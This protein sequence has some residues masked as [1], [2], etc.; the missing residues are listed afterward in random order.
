MPVCSVVSDKDCHLSVHF[1]QKRISQEPIIESITLAHRRSAIVQYNTKNIFSQLALAIKHEKKTHKGDPKRITGMIILIN[2]SFVFL[3]MP[4]VVLHFIYSLN[5]NY[6]MNISW[7]NRT[8]FDLLKS[9]CE[10]I[11]V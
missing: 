3:T 1:S 5:V 9:I 8:S 10:L 6:K 2:I 7:F 11:T 4:I